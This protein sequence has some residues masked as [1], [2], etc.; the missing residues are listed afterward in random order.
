MKAEHE[1]PGEIL[2][3]YEAATG[4]WTTADWTH[5]FIPPCDAPEHGHYSPCPACRKYLVSLEPDAGPVLC[6][7]GNSGCQVCL[8]AEEA[9]AAAEEAAAAAL[10]AMKRGEWREACREVWKCAH[11]EG[12]FGDCRTWRNFHDMVYG[13]C[14][15]KEEEGE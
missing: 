3:A 15:E 14:M 6:E 10:E 5:E 11:L 1:I 7:G 13:Y 12:D 2:A 9:A 4:G 8:D